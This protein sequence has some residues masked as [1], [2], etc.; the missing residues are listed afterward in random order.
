MNS[1]EEWKDIEDYIGYYQVSSLGNIRSLTRTIN[2]GQGHSVT[3]KGKI[4]KLAA[5]GERRNYPSIQLQIDGIK[6]NH[7][8]HRLVAKAFIPNPENKPEVNHK[9]GNTFN[10]RVE[11][12]EWCTGAENVRHA[13]A[14]GL[15]VRGKALDCSNTKRKVNVFKDGHFITTLVGTHAMHE[16]GLHYSKVLACLKG[17]RK[18]H[19]GFTFEEELLDSK[20]KG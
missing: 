5:T 10:N 15:L 7:K 14:T 12:L 13:V 9:D 1:I 20:E 19:K 2:N 17:Q 6:K 3:R 18:T 8:I 16:F 11:N 4:L